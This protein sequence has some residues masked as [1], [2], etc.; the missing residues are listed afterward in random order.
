MELEPAE[1]LPFAR[2][3]DGP[4]ASTS[5]RPTALQMIVDDV[6][7]RFARFS[8]MVVEVTPVELPSG[9]TDQSQR[10]DAMHPLCRECRDPRACRMSWGRIRIALQ[11][12]LAP[13]RGRG[14]C[15]RLCGVVTIR[16]DGRCA[17][18]C[19]LVCPFST[20]EKTF[21]RHIE[22]LGL[23]A[24]YVSL[25]RADLLTAAMF[26]TPTT[27]M[28]ASAR[29]YP[30]TAEHRSASAVRQARR[31][32]AY[33]ERHLSDPGLSVQG[34]ADALNISPAYLS[35]VFAECAGI[36]M[37]CYIT[38]RRIELA[39]TLLLT[40]DWQIK[41]IAFEAGY[42]NPDWFS[43]DFRVHTGSTPTAFRRRPVLLDKL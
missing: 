14:S 21:E 26:P 13:W 39:R 16:S 17:A 11:S 25:H 3:V 43:H 23:V 2:S 28:T 40:T 20:S 22:L 24:D 41:R 12:S 4:D 36:R 29:P 35:H 1:R 8:D 19:R 18:A 42:H 6:R 37:H 27:P 38:E 33:I 32:L 7:G 31:A 5:A 10:H 9:E 15:G 34:V 30:T